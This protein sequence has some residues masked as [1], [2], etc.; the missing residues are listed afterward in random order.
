[1]TSRRQWPMRAAVMIIIGLALAATPIVAQCLNP[2]VTKNFGPTGGAYTGAPYVIG[3]FTIPGTEPFQGS[4][5]GL[6]LL[7]QIE[8]TYCPQ[9]PILWTR[10]TPTGTLMAL[11][12]ENPDS[13]AEEI[14]PDGTILGQIDVNAANVQ[15]VALGAQEVIDFN[16]ELIKLPN[17]YQA[18]IAHVERLEPCATYPAQCPGRSTGTIDV[19]GDEVLVL[20]TNWNIVWTWNAFDFLPIGRAAVLGE[21]CTP[22]NNNGG[23]QIVLAKI[24]ND[25]LHSNSLNYDPTDGNLVVSVRHQ[26]WVIKIAYQDGVGDGHVV[27]TMGQDSDLGPGSSFTMLNSHGLLWPWF[28]HTHD[29]E[30]ADAGSGPGSTRIMTMFDNG[31][32]RHLAIGGDS[33]GMALVVDETDLTVDVYDASDMGYFSGALGSAQ[34]LPNGNMWYSAGHIKMPRFASGWATRM[35]E[36]TPQASGVGKLQFSEL[37]NNKTYR[38]F[39]VPALP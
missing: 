8:Y 24:A 14:R 32:T 28:S 9:Q 19:L 39:R 15:L 31:N 30:F 23:C 20:D 25:W 35:I 17:G 11:V 37:Y 13:V 6:N 2:A 26:D 1:M 10:L 16:H 27:W 18:V 3:S 4:V 5:L 21:H 33:R 36:V 22:H 34:M 38:T 7:G 29:V 12:Y